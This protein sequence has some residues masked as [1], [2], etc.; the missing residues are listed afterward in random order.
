MS[1]VPRH[2][3]SRYRVKFDPVQDPKTYNAAILLASGMSTQMIAEET[4]LTPGMVSYR[5]KVGELTH[6]RRDFRN[7]KGRFAEAFLKNA[8]PIIE[9]ELVKHLKEHVDL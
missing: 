9:R 1:L 3:P 5:V 7:G 4:G 8:R 2:K 6:C